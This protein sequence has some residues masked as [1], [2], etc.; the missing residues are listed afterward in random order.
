[1]PKTLN[2]PALLA[3]VPDQEITREYMRRL[4]LR[5]KRIGNPK[6]LR[7]CQWCGLELG[8]REMRQ[9]IPNCEKRKSA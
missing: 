8:A 5:R 9:H 1:M 4:N 6:V 3:S 2:I 7:P